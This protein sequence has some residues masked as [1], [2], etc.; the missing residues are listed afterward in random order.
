MQI[1]VKIINFFRVNFK[2]I[3]TQIYIVIDYEKKF[4]F[5]QRH[6]TH[7]NFGHDL[8]ERVGQALL[9]IAKGG[10]SYTGPTILKQA[11]LQQHKDCQLVIY[12][13]KAVFFQFY[14]YTPKA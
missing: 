1:S 10:G 13:D 11:E 5:V 9:D 8:L 7:W 6:V 4:L 3:S 2:Q 14:F 12:S